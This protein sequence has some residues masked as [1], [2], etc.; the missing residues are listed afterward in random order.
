MIKKQK[1]ES[2]NGNWKWKLEIGNWKWKL[3]MEIVAQKYYR[4]TLSKFEF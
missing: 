2:G 4:K 1:I 3:E